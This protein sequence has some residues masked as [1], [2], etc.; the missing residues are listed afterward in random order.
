MNI[1]VRQISSLEKIRPGEAVTAKSVHRKTL[2]RGESFSYQIAVQTKENLRIAVTAES[3][4]GNDNIR[5]YSVKNTVMDFPSYPDSDDDYI[6][7]E[8]GL[9]PDILMPIENEGHHMRLAD[10]S[11]AVWV[12]VNV[13][14][15]AEPGVYP[16]TVTVAWS[17]IEDSARINEVMYLDVTNAVI[18]KQKTI[19]TQWFHAD[20]IADVHN[21]PVYSEE[22]WAL[23]DKYMALAAKL[24]INMIL[25]PVITPPLD[26]GEGL[27]RT[28]VQLVKIEKKGDTYLFD[29]SLLKRWISLVNK[30]NIKYI[31]ISHLFSQ[32]GLKYA[33]NIVVTQNGEE[34]YMFGWHV[35]SKSDEYRNFLNQFLPALIK[36]LENEGVKDRCWFHIS[37]EPNELHLE[38]YKYAYDIIKPLIGDCQTL[39]ALSNYSFYETGLVPNPATST[40]H[41]EPFLE[42][43]V[44]NQWAYYC[45]GQYYKVGNRFLAM[46]SYRNRILGL[47]MYKY[48][49][50]GFLHWGFNF[51][52]SQL[53]RNKIN[54][55][56]TSSS[57]KAFPS[58][59][60]F[61]V[62]PIKDGVVPSLRAVVFKEA[63]NDI[64]ICRTLESFIGRDEVIKMIDTAAGMELTFS[65]YPKNS[66]F[67]P[68]LMENMEKMI[69]TYTKK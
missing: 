24:G 47:Q 18:P 66:E 65:E 3:P 45:C 29:F 67:I 61:S 16:V 51:Y 64:E 32:W 27:R 40:N 37:D 49:I 13:P 69:K 48:N 43:N 20:C 5:L 62:Y 21:V 41:I 30:N 44:P 11:G 50:V 28:C 25:T 35:D 15:D 52:N 42:H 17:G 53:S 8:P 46:P 2:M 68:A 34:S 31:E 60:P 36:C 39:D 38:N 12:T 59:D 63:L 57:D 26:T 10:E 23:I 19:F 55:Y 33:P 1:T 58:G 4:L 9:M 22:H 14:E 54:P 56:V 7:K 6:T